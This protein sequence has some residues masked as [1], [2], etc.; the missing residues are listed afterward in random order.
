MKVRGGDNA[1]F[2]MFSLVSFNV[3]MR[4]VKCE[5]E[6]ENTNTFYYRC[7]KFTWFC[8]PCRCIK[9][10][11]QELTYAWYG[12]SKPCFKNIITSNKVTEYK[13]KC[14]N[15]IGSLNYGGR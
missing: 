12:S 8:N 11:E 10:V 9:P 13:E 14:S 1:A 3:S 4:N 15:K 6:S 5:P 2:Y 7:N